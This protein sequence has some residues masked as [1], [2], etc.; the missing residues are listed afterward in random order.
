MVIKSGRY[1]LPVILTKN[2]NNIENHLKDVDNQKLHTLTDDDLNTPITA[3]MRSQGSKFKNTLGKNSKMRDSFLQF[4]D[5]R[6][7]Q[8]NELNS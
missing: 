8:E 2:L 4:R 6:I 1:Q 3:L 7:S 5:L